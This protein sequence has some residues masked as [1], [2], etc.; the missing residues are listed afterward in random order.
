MSSN[1]T[2]DIIVQNKLFEVFLPT[3]LVIDCQDH[4]VSDNTKKLL[5]ISLRL[6]LVSIHLAHL[7]TWQLSH[8]K[9]LAL[10]KFGVVRRCKVTVQSLNSFLDSI[11]TKPPVFCF[12]IVFSI[13]I[14]SINNQIEFSY[15]SCSSAM[16]L[17]SGHHV[18]S[19]QKQL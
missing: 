8:F 2:T 1:F 3:D 18:I 13:L 11:V 15:Q 7:N 5:G 6:L 12:V 14:F 16:Y 17:I 9:S 10:Q 4:Q 19:K